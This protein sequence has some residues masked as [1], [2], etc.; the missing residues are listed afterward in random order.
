MQRWLDSLGWGGAPLETAMMTERDVA[1][2]FHVLGAVCGFLS[3][4]C[5]A[6]VELIPLVFGV[7]VLPRLLEQTTSHKTY[8]LCNGFFTI[9]GAIVWSSLYLSQD[10]YSVMHTLFLFLSLCLYLCLLLLNCITGSHSLERLSCPNEPQLD[11]SLPS[12]PSINIQAA[13]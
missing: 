10:D 4:F 11:P 13:S 7:L 5:T 1:R 12:T 9:C 3:L 6:V 2:Y 8:M